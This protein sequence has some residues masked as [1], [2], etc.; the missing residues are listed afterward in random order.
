MTL[1]R[2]RHLRELITCY[3]VLRSQLW[4]KSSKGIVFVSAYSTDNIISGVFHI[5][6]NLHMLNA[7]VLQVDLHP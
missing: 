3:L 7:H 4:K 6:I 5:I 1:D 2:I